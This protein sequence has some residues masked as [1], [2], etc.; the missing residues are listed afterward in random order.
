MLLFFQ[1]SDVP[2]VTFTDGLPFVSLTMTTSTPIS[3]NCLRASF[4]AMEPMETMPMTIDADDD[5]DNGKD[6]P[7]SGVL[8]GW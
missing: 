4:S 3:L 7:L 2:E 6:C 1:G 5:A 8:Q